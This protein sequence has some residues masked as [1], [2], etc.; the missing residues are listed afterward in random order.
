MPSDLQTDVCRYTFE[1][2]E[3][4]LTHHKYIR[5]INGARSISPAEFPVFRSSG[6]HIAE[7]NTFTSVTVD[8]AFIF[9]EYP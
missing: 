3:I 2:D 8:F 6:T 7:L 1:K 4:I 9:E 5:E